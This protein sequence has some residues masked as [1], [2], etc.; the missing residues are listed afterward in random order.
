[1]ISPAEAANKVKETQGYEQVLCVR[2]YDFAHYVVDA[3]PK[4]G[5]LP[6]PG[7]QTTFGVHKETGE[8]TAFFPKPFGTLE[9]YQKAKRLDF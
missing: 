1:M 9:K 7:V 5:K 3:L 4:Q 6:G 2:D 8:V